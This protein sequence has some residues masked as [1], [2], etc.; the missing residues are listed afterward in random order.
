MAEIRKKGSTVA[1]EAETVIKDAAE[2]TA[3]GALGNLLW[4]WAK[5]GVFITVL[6]RTKDQITKALAD[7]RGEFT[8][9]M[10]LLDAKDKN[11][12]LAWYQQAIDSYSD[13][14]FTTLLG[15]LPPDKDGSRAYL[16]KELNQM[17]NEEFQQMLY[18]L[19]HD[20]L[21]S[22]YRR[23]KLNGGRV[24]AEELSTVRKQMHKA[25]EGLVTFAQAVDR[26]AGAAAPQVGTFLDNLIARARRIK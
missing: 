5:E 7:N 8:R 17:T 4:K 12:L 21:L 16:L 14:R 25:G 24:I 18:M 10:V 22:M 13:D 1:K 23:F 20:N 2:V 6:E 9:D 3:L 11:N 15:K 26:R 19:E